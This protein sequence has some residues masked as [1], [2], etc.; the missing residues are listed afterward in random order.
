MTNY[1]EPTID[2][3]G[4]LHYKLR[5][6]V[7]VEAIKGNMDGPRVLD[8]AYADRD[9]AVKVVNRIDER[10]NV[11][12]VDH[13]EQNSSSAIVRAYGQGYYNLPSVESYGAH[14]IL[15]VEDLAA[16]HYMDGVINRLGDKALDRVDAKFYQVSEEA[17][18]SETSRAT[19]RMLDDL[20]RDAWMKRELAELAGA[21]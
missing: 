2:F 14:S 18:Q 13:A 16:T 20:Q 15:S 8:S 7:Y 9:E 10:R 11:W 4:S 3:T 17:R 1:T 21:K 12:L 19:Q 6:G 5:F